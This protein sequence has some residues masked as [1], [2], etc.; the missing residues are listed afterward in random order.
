[1]REGFV[2]AHPEAIVVLR[3]GEDC[4]SASLLAR[5][6]VPRLLYRLSLAPEV[7]A[8]EGFAEGWID[9]LAES[10]EQAEERLVDSA[11]SLAARRAVSRL[12]DFPSREA[13]LA[14]ERAEFALIHARGDK[15]EG[16]GAFFA[17]RAPEF[18]NR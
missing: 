2:A 18:S 12:A 13:A 5:R 7:P 15:K 10:Q 14:L 3:R 1:M 16:I 6:G 8:R 4:V 17:R 11:L 9:L